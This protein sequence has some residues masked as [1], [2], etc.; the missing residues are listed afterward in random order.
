MPCCGEIGTRRYQKC[1]VS[2]D[3]FILT[4][5]AASCFDLVKV[6]ELKCMLTC[7]AEFLLLLGI[8]LQVGPRHLRGL[9]P[10]PSLDS[11]ADN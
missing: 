4:L 5:T 2:S 11:N 8:R 1:V 3:T 9:V 7:M 10:G 6:L